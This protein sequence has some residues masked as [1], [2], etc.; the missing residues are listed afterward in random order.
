MVLGIRLAAKRLSMSLS[1]AVFLVG[2]GRQQRCCCCVFLS[3]CAARRHGQASDV[4]CRLVMNETHWI[5]KD[6]AV[7]STAV[8]RRLSRW[9]VGYRRVGSHDVAIFQAPRINSSCMISSQ[10]RRRRHRRRGT[11]RRG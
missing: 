8:G 1:M 5:S 4:I 3:A 7:D 9:F 2:K 10:K 11:S 6:S